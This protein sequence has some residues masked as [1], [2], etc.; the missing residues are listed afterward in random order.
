M[1]RVRWSSVSTRGPA[2]GA[3]LRPAASRGATGFEQPPVS[4]SPSLPSSSP[5]PR[6]QVSVGVCEDTLSMGAILPAICILQAWHSAARGRLSAGTQ[7]TI[8]ARSRGRG[9]GEGDILDSR[10]WRARRL[11]RF[12]VRRSFSSRT[13][14]LLSECIRERGGSFSERVGR[15]VP[16]F[17]TSGRENI[18]GQLRDALTECHPCDLIATNLST[19]TR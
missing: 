19:V 9:P 15:A 10:T 5:T 16:D 14:R 3:A 13:A 18:S 2:N 4:A 6:R 8:P 17:L 11:R 7:N 1:K 12:T